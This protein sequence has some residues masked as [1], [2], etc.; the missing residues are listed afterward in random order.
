ME[1]PEHIDIDV[2]ALEIGDSLRVGD[3]P[4]VEGVSYVDDPDSVVVSV[5]MPTRVVEPEETEEEAAEA[6]EGAPEGEQAPEG[7]APDFTDLRALYV[8]CTLK[9]SPEPYR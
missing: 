4:A 7:A 2:A 8:N 3:L 9:R 6:A 1:V 5:T